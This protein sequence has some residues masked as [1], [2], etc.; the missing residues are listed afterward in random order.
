MHRL[1]GRSGDTAVN[2]VD[3]VSGPSRAHN[4]MLWSSKNSISSM[5]IVSLCIF[6]KLS[7]DKLVFHY[8]EGGKS[9][10]KHAFSGLSFLV[11]FNF[12]DFVVVYF[13]ILF[14]LLFSFSSLFL[15][16]SATLLQ[17]TENL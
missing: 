10:L 16:L 14:L 3:K 1:C 8:V 11:T 7:V 17:F 4:L 2:N 5:E 6:T 9:F 13:L 15:K 12:G